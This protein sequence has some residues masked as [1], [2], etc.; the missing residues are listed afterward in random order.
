MFFT[1]IVIVLVEAICSIVFD[2]LAHQF[3]DH[4]LTQH[5]AIAQGILNLIVGIFVG[6]LIA[7]HIWLYTKN[8]STY[9][10]IVEQRVK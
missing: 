10:Y 3:L 2:I 6:Y 1:L 9:Q 7:F 4:E 8:K 5:M